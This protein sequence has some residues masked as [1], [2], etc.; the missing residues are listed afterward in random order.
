MSFASFLEPLIKP[1]IDEM[2]PGW[3]TLS[4]RW[5]LGSVPLSD[6]LTLWTSWTGLT[7]LAFAT[8]L[9]F[10]EVGERNELSLVEGVLGGALVGLAQWFVLRPHLP[11]A[12]RWIV[13]TVLSWGALTLF[14]IGAL[15]WMA[16]GTS[17]LFFR[18]L[19]GIAYGAYVGTGL[20]VAQWFA[21][22]RQIPGAWRWISL[23]A[24]V[25]AVGIAFGWLVGGILRSA[26]HL[27]VSEVFGLMVAWGAIA[28]LSGVGIVSL[29]YQERRQ[30]HGS[31][32][33]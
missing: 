24:G 2:T 4:K 23:S 7:W 28:A 13:A 18:S 32:V 22:R 1:L 17:N 14:H 21:I 5:G 10:V 11:T 29:L 9:L 33:E 3:A 31:P 26:S 8:S 30:E 16:P 20:G 12:A 25:W 15:G 27:F 6:G 19:L